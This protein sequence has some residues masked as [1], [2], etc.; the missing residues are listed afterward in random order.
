MISLVTNQRTFQN[1]N[2]YGKTVVYLGTW[3]WV[4]G[5]LKK[6]FDKVKVVSTIKSRSNKHKSMSPLRTQMRL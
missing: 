6:T 2:F 1:C 3:A 5:F 4:M